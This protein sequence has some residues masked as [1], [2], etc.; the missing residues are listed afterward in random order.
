MDLDPMFVV[1]LVVG[2]LLV[3]GAIVLVVVLSRRGSRAMS[4]AMGLQPG[5][6]ARAAVGP[7][8]DPVQAWQLAAPSSGRSA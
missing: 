5:Q 8:L 6:P 1:G 4:S 7:K 2:L 3:S